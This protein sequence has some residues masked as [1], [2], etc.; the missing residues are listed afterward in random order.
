M[1]PGE[2]KYEIAQFAGENFSNWKCGVEIFLKKHGVAHC[3]ENVAL[4]SESEKKRRLR[5]Q[6][7]NAIALLVQCI[8]DSH[9]EYVNDGRTAKEIWSRTCTT[10]EPR[11]I[12][13][14]FYGREVRLPNYFY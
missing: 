7:A 13:Y 9:L 14:I 6:D 10:F 3:W 2:E 1:G 4:V 8:A 11:A 12:K 5:K